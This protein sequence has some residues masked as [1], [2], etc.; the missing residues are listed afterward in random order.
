MAP[1]HPLGLLGGPQALSL[2]VHLNSSLQHLH[3]GS[4]DGFVWAKAVSLLPQEGGWARAV[5][6]AGATAGWAMWPRA[7]GPWRQA[8]WGTGE[9]GSGE[10]ICCPS[11]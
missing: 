2:L 9:E 5:H 1:L 7:P 10:V 3:V 4:R 11:F 6:A 8:W